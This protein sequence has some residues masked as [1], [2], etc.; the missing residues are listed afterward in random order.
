MRPV[1]NEMALPKVCQLYALL[2]MPRRGQ[3]LP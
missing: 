3:W 1:M 2:G